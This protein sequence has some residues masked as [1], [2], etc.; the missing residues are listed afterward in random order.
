VLL[1]PLSFE[2]PDQL[3]ALYHL[4]PGFGTRELPQSLATYFT[5]SDN[6]RVFEDIGL[7][8]A[9]DVSVNRRGE[10]EQL[11]ALR[12]TDGMLTLLDIRP[13]LGRLVRKE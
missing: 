13:E 7:R 8:N 2:A 11:K 5:Y 12:V 6:A 1:K 4:A 10:P 3:V 9:Q